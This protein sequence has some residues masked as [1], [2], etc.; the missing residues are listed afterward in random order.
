MMNDRQIEVEL[1]PQGI[2]AERIRAAGA[3][4]IA[5][6]TDV[7]LGTSFAEG[8]R[9]I[10][11]RGREYLLVDAL[12]GD[13]ALLCADRADHAG[14]CFWRGSNA[15]MNVVMGTAC[16]QVIV[17]AK[18]IVATGDIEPESVHLPGVFVDQV[19]PAR[20]RRHLAES[21]QA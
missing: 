14:N 5:F 10:E 20:P 19:V 9:T 16:E 12:S 11:L 15:N 4:I 1:W 18:E 7:G 3:G 2:F 21:E 17:E 6:V 13:V 8:R